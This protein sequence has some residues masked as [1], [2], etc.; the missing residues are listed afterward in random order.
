MDGPDRKT[1]AASKADGPRHERLAKALRAN[2]RRRKG[3]VVQTPQTPSP[4]D[5]RDDHA[6]A[7]TD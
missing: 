2:L 7:N 6:D 5:L 4:D 1:L 3:G